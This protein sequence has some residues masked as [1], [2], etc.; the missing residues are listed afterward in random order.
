MSGMGSL[1]QEPAA[2]DRLAHLLEI[3]RCP[4]LE[5]CLDAERPAHPC[6]KI[7]LYQWHLIPGARR[8]AHW[9]EAHQL[10]EPWVG[11]LDVAKVLFVSSNPSIRGTISAEAVGKAA[12]ADGVTWDDDDAEIIR[13]FESA[14]EEFI[15][16]GTRWVGGTSTVRY[17][18]SI[19]ARAKELLPSRT[20]RP[21]IDYALT[22][23]VRC[24]SPNEYGMLEAL[25]T[26]SS[27][28]LMRTLE[29][30]GARIIVGIG[31]PAG[32]RLRQMLEVPAGQVSEVTLAGRR[33]L[34]TFLP[35]P[36]SR[37]GLKTFAGNVSPKELETLQEFLR[38]DT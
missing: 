4:I 34:V 22:E 10:P 25:N 2:R 35:H 13:R 6:A 21:G 23:A 15:R 1:S 8:L 32:E 12:R 5:S 37:G 24:K 11:H 27:R 38:G 19:K 7:A 33:R 17:W 20:V 9:R 3:A 14:Y 30:S 18:S 31:I 16:D 28:Y 36:N 29:L 26:C